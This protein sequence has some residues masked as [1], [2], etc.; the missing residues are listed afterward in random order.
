MIRL[1]RAAFAG[2]IPIVSARTA[3]A[4]IVTPA[5]WRLTDAGEL[6]VS[7]KH[8]ES[9]D[10]GEQACSDEEHQHAAELDYVSV[11]VTHP[12]MSAFLAVTVSMLHMD[13]G[14]Y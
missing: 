8:E 12:H 13:D 10:S 4:L 9:Q 5:R 11:A 14:R 1:S 2:P 3:L 6:A 7:G